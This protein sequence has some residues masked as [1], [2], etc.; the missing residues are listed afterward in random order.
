MGQ[1]VA[2]AFGRV[3]RRLRIDAEMTQE[4]LGLEADIQR[5]YV[6]SLELGEKQPS[7]TTVFKLAA[8][9]NIKPAKLIALVD[10]EMEQ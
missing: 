5:N 9:L 1:T 10:V 3:L 8:A 2:I 7:L 4:E 6:S